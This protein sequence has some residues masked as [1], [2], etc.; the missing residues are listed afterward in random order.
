[1]NRPVLDSW[2][3]VVDVD[4]CLVWSAPLSIAGSFFK[5]NSVMHSGRRAPSSALR[6]I[7]QHLSTLILDHAII[8]WHSI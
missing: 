4:S 5:T 3:V 7:L 2:L 1:M 6:Q 8:L